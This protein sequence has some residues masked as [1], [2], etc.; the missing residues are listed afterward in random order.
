MDV[1][2]SLGGYGDTAS[3]T[4]LLEVGIGAA[5]G[6]CDFSWRDSLL[7]QTQQPKSNGGVYSTK[8]QEH[9]TTFVLPTPPCELTSSMEVARR[10]L[11]RMEEL[12]VIRHVDPPSES[13]A[14]WRSYG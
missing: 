1:D 12:W 10:K 11:R 6:D 14:G 13:H 9:A 7:V 3:N 8:L 5:C 4:C 2:R